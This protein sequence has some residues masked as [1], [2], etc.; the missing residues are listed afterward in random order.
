[1]CRLVLLIII[2][3]GVFGVDGV[4]VKSVSVMEGDSVTLHTDITQIQ[5]NDHILWR[6][7]PQEAIIAE[8]IEE[9]N[10]YFVY[11]DEDEHG[12]FIHKLHLNH[13]TGSL[14]ITD[15]RKTNSGLYKLQI[16]NRRGTLYRIFRVNVYGYYEE[17]EVVEEE[18]EEPY[19]FIWPVVVGSL[20]ALLLAAVIIGVV[21]CFYKK[22]INRA[23]EASSSPSTRDSDV[24]DSRC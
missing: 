22:K 23:R 17:G 18:K 21:S 3:N 14:T 9:A 11:D 8:I 13:Q 15:T 16:F 10:L 12:R 24:F 1:M 2:A 7:G 19:E 5:R 6:F 4:E 20:V